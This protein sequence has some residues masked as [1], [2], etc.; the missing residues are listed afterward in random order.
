MNGLKDILAEKK[1]IILD[2]DGTMTDSEPVNFIVY[3]RML[4][5]LGINFTKQD[6]DDVLGKT[7]DEIAKVIFSKYEVVTEQMILDSF[8]TYVEIFNKVQMEMHLPMFKYVKEILKYKDI[9]KYVLSNQIESII[10]TTLNMWG[11]KDEFDRI[12]ACRTLGKT[13]EFVYENCEEYFGVKARE[14]VLCEDT[15]KYLDHAKKCGMTTIGI[16]HH[17]NKI[18]SA[19]LVINEDQGVSIK[20]E[21]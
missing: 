15:Q 3:Q 19:D 4:A 20:D 8:D 2:F 18:E 13:K 11:V 5:P 16:K 7:I 6:F 12:L 17:L 21:R 10:S 9:K 1:V 14:C